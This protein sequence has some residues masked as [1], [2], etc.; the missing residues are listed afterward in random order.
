MRKQ[1][2]DKE[3]ARIALEALRDGNTLQQISQKYGVHQSQI[4]QWKKKLIENA[5]SLFSF[6]GEQKDNELEKEN[7]ELYKAIGQLKVECDYLK[8]KYNQMHSWP[9]GR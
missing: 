2:S 7:E 9:S 8:K 6:K 4:T 5:A 1:W 3:K